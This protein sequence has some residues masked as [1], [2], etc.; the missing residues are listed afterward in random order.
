M[1]TRVERV[2]KTRMTKKNKGLNLS[3][4][5]GILTIIMIAGF[6]AIGMRIL[7]GLEVTNLTSDVPWGTW[8]AFY[9]YFVGLSAGAFLLSSLIHVFDMRHLEKVGRD[10]TIVAI[11]SMVLALTFILLDIGRMER[12]WHA[13]VYGNI[14]SVLAWEVRFYMVYLLLLLA[15]LWFA[16]R[17]DLVLQAQ[18]TGFKASLARFLKFGSTDTSPEAKE[19]DHRWLKILGAIGIPIAI[20]GVHGGTGL[21]YAVIKARP[22]WNTALF[23]VVFVVSALVSGTALVTAIYIV[24]TKLAKEK[25]DLDLVKSLAGL[26]ILFLLID[27]GLQFFEILVGFYGLQE[28]TLVAL[29]FMIKGGNAWIFW[30]VQIGIGVV[31]PIAIYANKKARNSANAMMAAAVAIVVGILGVR[32]NIVL[33]AQ[34]NPLLP[35]LPLP[36]YNP[37]LLEWIVSFGIIAMGFLL[38]TLAVRLLPEETF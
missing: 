25:V 6:A 38:F 2:A 28:D 3:F 31:V 5:Y 11:V 21:L 33:P 20:F 30:L 32:F 19:K 17:H 29:L 27:V 18:G 23:P 4:W 8:V 16:L 35:G 15:E 10:A 22:Y 7:N 9:I 37:T 34:I 26:M 36:Q 12:V 13:L 1:S 24:K 14:T